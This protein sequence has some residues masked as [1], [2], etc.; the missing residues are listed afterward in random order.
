MDCWPARFFCSWDFPG[1]NTG[2]GSHLLLQGSSQPKGSNPR[3]LHWQKDSLP[4]SHLESQYLTLFCFKD[5]VHEK[6]KRSQG[7]E[8]C[9]FYHNKNKIRFPF[10]LLVI[11]NFSSDKTNIKYKMIKQSQI[12]QKL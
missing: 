8:L 10:T 3:L 1:K 6:T 11:K 12:T 9:L 2:V 5:R 7:K 4:H